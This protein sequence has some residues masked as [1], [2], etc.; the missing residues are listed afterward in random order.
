MCGLAGWY[1]LNLGDRDRQETLLRLLMR[2][3]Q[4]RGTDSFGIAFARGSAIKVRR[5]LGPV[6]KW[7]AKDRKRVREAAS[8]PIV[9]GHTRA[10]SRGDV[11]VTNAHPF[12]V[13]GRWV[14]A[15]N[16]CLANS[17]ELML[18]A[19]YAPA[20]ETDSEEA[21][22]WLVTENLA[23]S[24][25]LALRGWYAMTLVSA[26]ARELV[27]AVDSR[28]PFAIAR[29]GEGVIWHS[30]ASALESSLAAVGIQAEVE[31]LKSTIL[32][33]P[34]GT[35]SSLT[36]DSPPLTALS[37]IATGHLSE[38]VDAEDQ[39]SFGGWNE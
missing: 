10:A 9:L 34:D 25:F 15:H 22:S 19:K 17:S 38:V 30:L 7:L 14:G 23:E 16:G 4:V 28:T 20:G 33:L 39:L 1:G 6:S 36:A 26:D 37:R 27:L 31:E 35:Q 29:V 3:A 12:R 13:G 32:R 2:K 21:L 24:A 5:G 8:S 11:T 18:A